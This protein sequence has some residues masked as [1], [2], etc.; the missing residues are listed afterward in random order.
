MKTMI[1][2][3]NLCK[4]YKGTE[5][6]AVDGI[7]FDVAEGEFFA[8]LGPNGAGKTTTISI[9]TT[10]LSKTSGTV[11]IAG[12]DLDKNTAQIRK[13][14]GIIFQKP[15][16]DLNLSAEVNIRFHACMY[17]MY[18]YRPFFSWMPKAYQNRVMQLAEI[19][20]VEDKLRRPLK[21]FSGGMRRKIEIVR[22][23]IHHPKVLF[24]D[25]PTQG[26]D[27]VSRRSLWEYINQTRK[28][29]G[30]TIFLTTH[31]IDEAENVDRICVVKNGAVLIS[32]SPQEMKN[33]LLKKTLILDAQNRESLIVELREGGVQPQISEKQ[34]AVPF[35]EATPMGILGKLKTPLTVM[36][37]VEPT[38]EDAYVSLITEKENA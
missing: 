17:G 8:L 6:P 30:T 18:V 2:V 34:I 5:K 23:L 29:E 9:L 32:A 33:S 21:T 25:E 1:H 28:E 38:L 37:T 22:S 24:L 7:G 3:D 19:M 26:L 11:T 10:I 35:N 14:V 4:K 31:Y 12:L 13:N 16:V 20:G 15:S 27:A 36:R